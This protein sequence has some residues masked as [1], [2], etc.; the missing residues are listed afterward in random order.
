[1][2]IAAGTAPM[3]HPVELQGGIGTLNLAELMDPEMLRGA[4]RR[5]ALL[6]IPPGC[7]IGE[8][9]H[10]GE[11]EGFYVLS[12]EGL[13]TDNDTSYTITSGDFVLCKDGERHGVQ[14]QQEQDLELFILILHTVK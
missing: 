3:L 9:V 11:C 12:G 5:V 6:T 14:N 4:G 10:T 1:M 13:Y 2:K 7:S 8:H